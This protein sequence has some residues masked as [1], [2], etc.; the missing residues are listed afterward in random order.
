MSLVG[1]WKLNGDVNDSSINGAHGINTDVTWD[2]GGIIGQ[3]GSFD[4]S[5]SYVS[6]NDVIPYLVGKSYTMCAWIYLTNIPDVGGA[7]IVSINKGDESGWQQRLWRIATVSSIKRMRLGHS[8]N[9]TVTGEHVISFNRWYHVCYIYDVITDK[10]VGYVDGEFD[11][12]GKDTEMNSDVESSN[13][14]GIGG[15]LDYPGPTVDNSFEGL[16]NDVRIYD[17]KLSLQEI[18]NLAEAKVLHWKCD[19]DRTATGEVVVDSSDYG[20]HAIIGA[21]ALTWSSDTG[22]GVGS[23]Y[24]PTGADAVKIEINSTDFPVVFVDK[25]TISIWIKVANSITGTDT[26]FHGD[27]SSSFSSSYG[28]HINNTTVRWGV[29]IESVEYTDATFS[30]VDDVWH[31]ICCTYDGSY[32]IVYIDGNQEQKTL[33]S[34]GDMDV[35]SGITVGEAGVGGRDYVGHI[36]DMR[37]YNKVFSADEVL[38]LYKTSAALDKNGNLWC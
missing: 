25:I 7:E 12:L 29:D 34:G 22:K 3:A 28:I 5:G 17:H 19:L 15:E 38:R 36:T 16:I 37:L 27:I 26:V 18:Q 21:D 13:F 10:V 31:H 9:I 32:G 6:I 4:G 24:F 11:G 2:T 1:W 33:L 30:I 14:M 23:Y 8:N 20:H 35:Q